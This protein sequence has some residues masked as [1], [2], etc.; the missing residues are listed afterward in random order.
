VC[1]W[2]ALG[3]ATGNP[4]SHSFVKSSATESGRRTVLSI[5]DELSQNRRW[6]RLGCIHYVKPGKR[7]HQFFAPSDKAAAT[8]NLDPGMKL[9]FSPSLAQGHHGRDRPTARRAGTANRA[10]PRAEASSRHLNTNWVGI[11][12]SPPSTIRLASI[13]E[14]FRFRSIKTK[15]LG[16]FLPPRLLGPPSNASAPQGLM[17]GW[18]ARH[19]RGTHL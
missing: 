17:K 10:N 8:V 9:R 11:I 2:R 15:H 12:I 3:V 14:T 19:F 1:N 6:K 13:D 18:S 7:A 4:L 5:D 16:Q